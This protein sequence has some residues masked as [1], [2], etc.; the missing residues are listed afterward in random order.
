MVCIIINILGE[1]FALVTELR[2]DRVDG[3]LVVVE[4]TVLCSHQS[5][6]VEFNEGCRVPE[7]NAVWPLEG[8]A[9]YKQN[10]T[11]RD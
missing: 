6:T 11:K 5:S 7:V 2:I 3:E 4:A 1:L 10:E 9:H 8:D